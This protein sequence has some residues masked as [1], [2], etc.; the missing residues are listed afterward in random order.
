MDET[1]NIMNNQGLDPQEPDQNQGGILRRLRDR[2]LLRKRKAEAEEKETYQVA[3]KRRH[4]RGD[5][6]SGAGRRGRPRKAENLPDVLPFQEEEEKKKE[7][8]SVQ[9]VPQPPAEEPLPEAEKAG[10]GTISYSPLRPLA[11][12]PMAPALLPDVASVQ[13]PAVAYSSA[14]LYPLSPTLTPTPAPGPVPA[15]VPIIVPEPT[16]PTPNT[17]L[18]APSGPSQTE[19]PLEVVLDLAPAPLVLEPVP[20]PPSAVVYTTESSTREALDQVTIEDLGPDE[21][22]DVRSPQKEVAVERFDT[23]PGEGP[24]PAVVERT[25]I[26]SSPL[27]TSLS[28]TQGYFKEN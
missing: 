23:D 1:L 10:L 21:L 6:R 7:E 15:V 16:V 28:T 17:T 18:P 26:L 9:E 5:P 4:T 22:E 13:A 25:T 24:S 12:I 19:T 2:D 14:Y 8:E 11:Y 20:A 27:F 3:S